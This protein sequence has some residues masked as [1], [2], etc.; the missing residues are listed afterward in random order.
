MRR[1]AD[2]FWVGLSAVQFGEND[3]HMPLS[4]AT[5]SG[6][7]IELAEQTLKNELTFYR[8]NIVKCLPL[9]MGKIRYPIEQEMSKCFPNFQE[10]LQSLKPSIVFLLGKQVA[11]F[12]LKQYG[13]KTVAFDEN[14]NFEPIMIENTWFV[15]V[16]HPSYI[17][18]YKRKFIEQYVSSLERTIMD[19]LVTN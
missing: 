17:L 7:L 6:A 10:E 1:P 11:T 18:V 8:T 16:Q 19:C 15:P 3:E 5:R 9:N 14:F 2:V 12:V 4:S 13:I